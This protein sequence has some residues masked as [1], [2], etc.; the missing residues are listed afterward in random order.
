MPN[1]G[2]AWDNEKAQRNS[3]MDALAELNAQ[4]EDI[5]I[6]SDADEII[7]RE[8]VENYIPNDELTALKIDTYRYYLNCLEAKQNW[9]MP[10]I[11]K[12]KYLKQHTPD[13]VRNSGY[14]HM[15]DNGGWHFS[16]IGDVDFV[17]RKIESFSHTELNTEEFKSKLEYKMEHCQSLFGDDFWE[18]VNIDETFPKDVVANPEKY[19]HLIKQK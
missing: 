8:V 19:S 2:N 3:I 15:I 10:R 5:I 1:T 17:K 6:I 13:K 9:I 7:R 11:M 12:Y 14:E 4:D 16:Y 18:V